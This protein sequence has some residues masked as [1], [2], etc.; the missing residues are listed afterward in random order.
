MR[1]RLRSTLDLEQVCPKVDTHLMMVLTEKPDDCIYGR[2]TEICLADFTGQRM[3][4]Q[5]WRSGYQASLGG[6]GSTLDLEHTF[7]IGRSRYLAMN[8]MMKGVSMLGYPCKENHGY[9]WDTG[10][11]VDR[12]IGRAKG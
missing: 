2:D 6:I 11:D 9:L 4:S 8:A 12:R 10:A 5:I 7:S 1:T 3:L